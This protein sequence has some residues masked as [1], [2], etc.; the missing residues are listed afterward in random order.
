MCSLAPLFQPLASTC[1]LILLVSHRLE[2]PSSCPS[3]DPAHMTLRSAPALPSGLAGPPVARADPWLCSPLGSPSPPSPSLS[4]QSPWGLAEDRCPS[5]KTA[6]V[7][8]QSCRGQVQGLRPKVSVW[9]RPDLEPPPGGWWRGPG[10]CF[11]FLW[12][13]LFCPCHHQ[14]SQF[15]ER[16]QGPSGSGWSG[17]V[18]LWPFRHGSGSLGKSSPH[19]W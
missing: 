14:H 16:S 13:L 6:A 19:S 7:S 8:P 17:L 12:I 9:P 10:L 15:E 5:A 18:W 4:G 11:H 2:A 3:C 1:S